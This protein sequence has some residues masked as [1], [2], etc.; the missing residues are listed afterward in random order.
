MKILNLLLKFNKQTVR[1]KT[2]LSFQ[3]RPCFRKGGDTISSTR[4][5]LRHFI[6]GRVKGTPLVAKLLSRSYQLLT[7]DHI[8]SD[9]DTIVYFVKCQSRQGGDT[10]L[11]DT[12][13]D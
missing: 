5:T 1:F 11:I 13:W 8:G 6:R 3:L 2:F 12:A 7:L 9:L 10:S 4:P